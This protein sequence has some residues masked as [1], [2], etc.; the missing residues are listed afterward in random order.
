MALPAP[1]A[2]FP[3]IVPFSQCI[4]V[5]WDWDPLTPCVCVSVLPSSPLHY[6]P[7]YLQ[8]VLPFSMSNSFLQYVIKFLIYTLNRA[9][10]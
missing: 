2:S 8:C 9:G 10:F 3:V 1:L 7:Y 6:F 4:L 5:K